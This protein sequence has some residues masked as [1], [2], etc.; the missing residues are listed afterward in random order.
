[1]Q[2][3]AGLGEVDAEVTLDEQ[4]KGGAMVIGRPSG[5]LA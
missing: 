3:D 4:D 5:A 2:D 1:L